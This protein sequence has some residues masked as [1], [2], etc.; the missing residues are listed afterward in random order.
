MAARDIHRLD[1]HEDGVSFDTTGRATF[2]FDS[3]YKKGATAPTVQTQL[4]FKTGDRNSHSD[5][6]QWLVVAA[7]K[8]KYK[9][10]GT[11]NWAGEYGSVLTATDGDL[12]KS[13]IKIWDENAGDGV[14][15]DNTM[16]AP[17]DDDR[18]TAIGGGNA[19]VHKE[20]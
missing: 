13:R 10:V 20:K 1:T 15:Y 12:A 2:G 4:Q 14:V 18:T 9:G 5:S 16:G 17:D 11:I 3:K 6:Y 7:P 8:A 19:V